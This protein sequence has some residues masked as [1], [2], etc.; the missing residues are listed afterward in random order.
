MVI[1]ELFFLSGNRRFSL[2]SSA[3]DILRVIKVGVLDPDAQRPHNE[4][5]KVNYVSIL[6]EKLFQFEFFSIYPAFVLIRE[7]RWFQNSFEE[8]SRDSV[9][10]CVPL[11]VWQ[12]IFFHFH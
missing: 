11:R 5:T 10:V 6:I 12:G 9:S 4:G 2:R 3:N 8:F 7:L 1:N